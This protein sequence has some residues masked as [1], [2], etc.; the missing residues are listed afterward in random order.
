MPIVAGSKAQVPDVE[1][2]GSAAE[3]TDLAWSRSALALTTAAAA[4]LRRVWT[5]FGDVTGRMVALGTLVS[6]AMAWL[7]WLCWTRSTARSAVKERAL[8]D[9]VT[10]RRIAVGTT[11]FAAFALA[12]MLVPSTGS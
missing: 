8:A 12:L 6:A 1:L 2:P 10:L 5:D 3:R 4:M 9:Q 7:V 11:V